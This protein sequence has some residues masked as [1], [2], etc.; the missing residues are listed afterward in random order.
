MPHK[1][2]RVVVD[3]NVF[4][5]DLISSRPD[6]MTLTGACLS[7][8]L[9]LLYSAHLLDELEAVMERDKFR[10]WFTVEQGLKLIDAIVLAGIEVPDRPPSD[11]PLVCRDPDDNYL[12]AL[13]EDGQADLLI[14]GDKDVKAVA[15]PWVTVAPPADALALLSDTPLWGTHVIKVRTED[16]WN[17]IDAAGQTAI[18][19]A[20]L[21][22]IECS[23]GISAGVYD[24]KIL[25]ALVVP[26][27][28]PYW[29][30]DFDAALNLMMG[31]SVSSQPIISSPELVTIKLVPDLGETFVVVG[32]PT[33][34]QDILCLTLE[35]CEDVLTP[36]GKDPFELDGWRVHSI[37]RRPLQ[38]HEVRPASNPSRKRAAERVRKIRLPGLEDS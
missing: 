13:Y 36:E 24:K 14:S 18:F 20:A 21:S 2:I 33:D 37:G 5:T 3:V 15:L 4:I 34:V 26:G 29:Y 9:E 7:G 35:R 8:E 12:F 16:V 22:F 17:K 38:P 32:N 10:R 25:E 1:K 11:L 19:K 31:R 28:A 6:E 30:R 27:T 23:L